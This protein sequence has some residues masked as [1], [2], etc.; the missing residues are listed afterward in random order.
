MELGAQ[1]VIH[2]PVRLVLVPCAHRLVLENEIWQYTV[3]IRL[4]CA[5]RMEI[6]TV[7]PSPL[8]RK[9][10]WRSRAYARLLPKCRREVQQR[11]CRGDFGLARSG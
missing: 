4:G 1:Q 8:H 3:S 11:V 9:G 10:A 5:C 6:H 2:E 7:V